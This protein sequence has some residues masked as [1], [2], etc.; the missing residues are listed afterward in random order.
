M[1]VADIMQASP[2]L[3]VFLVVSLGA[4]LGI[5][6]FGPIKLGAAGALFIGLFVGNIVPELGGK[7][8]LV[9][10]LGLGLF[11]YTVGLS[12]GQTFFADLRRQA[13]LMFGLVFA[14]VVGAVA[15]IF[16]GKLLG[17]A[18][19]MAVGVFAGSLTTT[20]AL[21]AATQA[22][23][24][25][26]PGVGYSLG[27]PVGV[28]VAIIAVSMVV[29]RRWPAKN[30]VESFAGKSL[31]AGTALVRE[32]VSVRSVP[33][34]KEQRIRISYLERAGV[35]RVFVPGEELL[36]DDRIVIVGMKDDVVAAANAVGEFVDDHLAD[37]RA[38]VDFRSFVVSSKDIASKTVAALNITGRFG[39]VITRIHRGD[40][41]LLAKDNSVIELG[42]RLMVAFPRE[43]YD[44]VER[45]FGNSERQ[46]SQI[47]AISMGLGM[48]LGL[49][50]GMVE[51]SLPSGATFSLGAAAG[52][53][54]VGTILGALQK[55]GPLLWQ[56]P[57]AANQT[58]R[59]LGLLLFLAAVGIASGPAFAKTAFTETGLRSLALAFIVA[60]VVLLV[61]MLVGRFLG[62]SAQ[63]T[64]GA[65][66]GVLGQPAVLAFAA[67]KEND[68]RIESGYAAIFALGITVKII[69]VTA[70]VAF[71]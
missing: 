40:L 59:Q 25:S 6:P 8:S 26:V 57:L 42:D 29:S 23:G 13:K 35:T 58:I 67:S 71:A 50:L 7:L 5:I 22:T 53:L 19:D 27:Y 36:Q 28:V 12:A 49:L 18:P 39:G 64:A 69:L 1:S 21:A 11:V 60:V 66:A 61:S 33:G 15:T 44:A 65:M 30:D 2:L 56:M 9:Q 48:V 63:R 38:K 51:I 47:D 31:F 20:P 32:S 70:I 52:P 17:V 46:I 68:E 34:W 43:E 41:E 62:V 45:F 54:V 3:T 10:S 14:L 55:T 37:N 4:A 16:G 24:S